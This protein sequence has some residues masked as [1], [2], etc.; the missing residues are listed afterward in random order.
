VSGSDRRAC[1][2][3]TCGVEKPGYL[4]ARQ[5]SERA[6]AAEAPSAMASEVDFAM[7]SAAVLVDLR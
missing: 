3:E 2:P 7:E 5:G 6:T 1:D 4:S